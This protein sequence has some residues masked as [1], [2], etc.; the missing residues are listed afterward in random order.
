MALVHRNAEHRIGR[1]L[2][3]LATRP[4]QPARKIAQLVVTHGEIALL[5]AMSRPHVTVVRNRFKKTSRSITS[6]A[7]PSG[8]ISI[9]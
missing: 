7:V 9:G 1:L 3:M 2:L 5:A 4:H 8:W 6:A